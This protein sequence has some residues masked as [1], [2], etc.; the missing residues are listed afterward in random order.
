MW[1][2]AAEAAEAAE[3]APRA[4]MMAEPRLAI[5]GHRFLIVAAV[6]EFER[7]GVPDERMLEIREHRRGVVAPK[8]QR[9]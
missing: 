6:D 5:R 3:L 2:M 7:R 9:A 8:R 1:S 4:S